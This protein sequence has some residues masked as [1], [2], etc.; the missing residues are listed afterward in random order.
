MIRAIKNTPR[1]ECPWHLFVWYY[2]NPKLLM[3][4]YDFL[5]I[6][7]LIQLGNRFVGF[8][9]QLR[10]QEDQLVDLSHFFLP[11][12]KSKF[13]AACHRAKLRLCCVGS[14]LHPLSLCACK[15]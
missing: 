5:T 9:L 6:L 13:F 7:P 4:Q 11:L 1:R 2:Y 14:M 12:Q 3:V 10:L 8:L 15:P